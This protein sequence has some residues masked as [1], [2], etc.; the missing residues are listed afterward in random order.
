MNEQRCQEL[1]AGL[2]MLKPTPFLNRLESWRRGGIANS[3]WSEMVKRSRG[4]PL[5]SLDAID[6]ELQLAQRS[7]RDSLD[8]IGRLLALMGSLEAKYLIPTHLATTEER[9][10]AL[11]LGREC[12]AC[13]RPVA[14]TPVDPIRH[15]FCGACDKAHERAGRPDRVL[16][17]RER[18]RA[19]DVLEA[20]G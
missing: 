2:L 11:D 7:Y 13:L 18:R 10:M 19:L 1:A 9:E 20:T 16:W 12:Q 3:A 14:N 8:D 4:T 5:P 15:G 17:I 6:R